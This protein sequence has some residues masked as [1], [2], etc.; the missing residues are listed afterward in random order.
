MVFVSG[1]LMAGHRTRPE[2]TANLPG[3]YAFLSAD[4][5]SVPGGRSIRRPI[6]TLPAPS[7]AE[8]LR[9]VAA[10]ATAGTKAD[11]GL[12]HA[13]GNKSGIPA[14]SDRKSKRLNYSHQC[15]SSM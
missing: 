6:R 14:R 10:A 2:N 12:A 9:A 7:A 5:A 11:P 1:Q 3:I 13:G 15:A 4:S 8:S